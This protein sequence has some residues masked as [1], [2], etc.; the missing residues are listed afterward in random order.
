MSYSQV[1]NILSIQFERLLPLDCALSRARERT[2]RIR[3]EDH[4]LEDPRERWGFMIRL[5]DTRPAN[6]PAHECQCYRSLYYITNTGDSP[7]R[8]SELC[9]SGLVGWVG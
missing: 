8:V 6:V 1:F 3:D 5:F 2:A 9:N 4:F 7:N